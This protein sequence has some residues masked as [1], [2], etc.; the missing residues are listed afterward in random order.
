[1]KS[2]KGEELKRHALMRH[3]LLPVVGAHLARPLAK[4]LV[5]NF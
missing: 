2:P 5:F 4:L 3:V 1:M